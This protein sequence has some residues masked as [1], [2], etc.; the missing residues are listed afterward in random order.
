M[1]FDLTLSLYTIPIGYLMARIV[2]RN[3]KIGN[4]L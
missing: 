2:S 1:L 4:Q 3:L